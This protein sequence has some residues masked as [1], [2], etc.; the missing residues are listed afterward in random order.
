MNSDWPHAAARQKKGRFAKEIG[1]DSRRRLTLTTRRQGLR[2]FEVDCPGCDPLLK[3][4]E[5]PT[6]AGLEINPN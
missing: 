5:R 6:L 2:D 3:R 4:G 1:V